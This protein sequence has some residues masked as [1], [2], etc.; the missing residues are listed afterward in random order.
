MN[1]KARQTTAT[2]TAA[3]LIA[4]AV[5]GVATALVSDT[6]VDHKILDSEGF[7][8]VGITDGDITNAGIKDA[9]LD[10]THAGFASVKDVSIKGS[11]LNDV[12]VRDAHLE[13][14]RVQRASL[15]DV[16][17]D[18]VTVCHAEVNKDFGFGDCQLV[19][20]GRSGLT[21]H[22]RMMGDAPATAAPGDT[23][24][25]IVRDATSSTLTVRNDPGGLVGLGFET[26]VDP[27]GLQSL[28][29]TAAAGN[30]SAS[31]QLIVDGVVAEDF[32]FGE[33]VDL[34]AEDFTLRVHVSEE[35]IIDSSRLGLALDLEGASLRP[36]ITTLDVVAADIA[37]APLEDQLFAPF[38]ADDVARL[39]L[40]VAVDEFGNVDRDVNISASVEVT[41]V[42]SGDVELVG[43]LNDHARLHD[44]SRLFTAAPF[45]YLQ[46]V[47]AAHHPQTLELLV[48]EDLV[49]GLP[50]GGVNAYGTH[51]I[52]I[53]PFPTDVTMFAEGVNAR[54]ETMTADVN[55]SLSAAP[56]EDRT[57]TILG[58]NFTLPGQGTLQ[59]NLVDSEGRPVDAQEGWS[60]YIEETPDS[61]GV[62]M[63]L[64]IDEGMATVA[65]NLS[66]SAQ[67]TTPLGNFAPSEYLVCVDHDG[68]RDCA[69]GGELVAIETGE[70]TEV[71][72][73]VG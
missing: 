23:Y 22:A 34:P 44:D 31:F 45:S 57:V 65:Q 30:E 58:S 27:L 35:G 18:G 10:G 41:A 20:I 61:H 50:W 51:L 39:V 63:A 12:S 17:L 5:A 2:T 43:P 14:S 66:A 7:R 37:F 26:A 62:S 21:V 70:T 16:S 13:D 3:I 59:V 42:H 19:D 68:V 67:L 1:S 46:Q 49:P 48:R 56:V 55:I 32:A 47:D 11:Y 28:G 52:A 8:D 71:Q 9:S 15:K 73:V 40:S 36:A 4:V 53:S 25:I 60:L 69:N 24:D 33:T 38:H 29:F 72:I 64:A 54:G 6:T